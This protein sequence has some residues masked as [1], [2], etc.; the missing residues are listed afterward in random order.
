MKADAD[1]PI[2]TEESSRARQAGDHSGSCVAT[3]RRQGLRVWWR[4]P[5]LG[6]ASLVGAWDCDSALDWLSSVLPWVVNPACGAYG[7][8]RRQSQRRDR[9]RLVRP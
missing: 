4:D 1:Y 7:P 8:T 3:E 9:S 2:G 6:G 5:A